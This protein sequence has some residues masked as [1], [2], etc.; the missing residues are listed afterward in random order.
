MHVQAQPCM[1]MLG[2]FHPSE[3]QNSLTCLARC[4]P[5]FMCY[6]CSERGAFS[7]IA[8]Q[9]PFSS[10]WQGGGRA[11][12][13]LPQVQSGGE[14]AGDGEAGGGNILKKAFEAAGCGSVSDRFGCVLTYQL[15][16]QAELSQVFFLFPEPSSPGEAMVRFSRFSSNSGVAGGK[17][18]LACLPLSS[19]AAVYDTDVELNKYSLA[20][21]QFLFSC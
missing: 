8:S 7:E 10:S 17:V 21:T 15:V 5:S 9:R 1:L 3:W 14:M 6:I 18:S 2:A 11:F 19:S 16:T 4:T 12:S 13:L 20:E